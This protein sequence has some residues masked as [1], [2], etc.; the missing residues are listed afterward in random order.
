MADEKQREYQKNYD[1]KTKMISVKYALCDMDDYNRLMKYLE[2]T[3]K[4]VNG[5]IKELINDFFE[6]EKYVMSTSRIAD[7]F[8]DYNV[9]EEILKKL[10]DVV[11]NEKYEIIMKYCRE[12]IDYELDE[13]YNEKGCAFEEWIEHF[14]DD[15]EYGDIDINVSNKEFWKI[16]DIS[17]SD[18]MGEVEYHG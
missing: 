6:K 14:L 12:C 10:K 8:V 9:S 15:V 4:S 17:I 2:V 18:N 3:G 16:I 1:K 5:F 13:A 7:Y 11:G